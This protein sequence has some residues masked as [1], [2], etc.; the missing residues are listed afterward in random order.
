MNWALFLVC[1][2]SLSSCT[3]FSANEYLDSQR[4][5]LLKEGKARGYAEGFV[6]GCATAR[7]LLGDKRFNLQKQISRFEGEPSYS[8]GWER[9]AEQCRRKLQPQARKSRP[10]DASV[11][12][13]IEAAKEAAAMDAERRQLWDELKK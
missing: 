10:R 1:L 13:N 9:G 3:R 7:H 5:Q 8:I 2:I 6:D 12:E 11:M 4:Q